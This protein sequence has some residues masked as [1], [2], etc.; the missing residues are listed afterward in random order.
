MSEITITCVSGISFPLLK[1]KKSQAD[2]GGEKTRE[3]AKK[4]N[5]EKLRSL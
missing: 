5:F 2:K 4:Y 1:L 3:K